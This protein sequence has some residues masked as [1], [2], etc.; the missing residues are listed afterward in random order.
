MLQ[1]RALCLTANID[2]RTHTKL[3]RHFN[4]IPAY[5]FYDWNLAVKYL[6]SYQSVCSCGYL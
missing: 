6:K 3:L 5:K 2:Y 1:K 4:V